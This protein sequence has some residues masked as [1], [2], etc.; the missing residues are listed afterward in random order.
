MILAR[1]AGWPLSVA[2]PLYAA[3]RDALVPILWLNGWLGSDFVWRGTPISS[4]AASEV[5]R[6]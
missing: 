6:T 4:A 3:M 5:G 1:A 2:Y